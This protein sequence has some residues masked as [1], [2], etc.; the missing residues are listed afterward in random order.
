MIESGSYYE[1]GGR[2]WVLAE[3]FQR[4][5]ADVKFWNETAI[6]Y[7]RQLNETIRRGPESA[8]LHIIT[9]EQIN[10]AWAKASELL[11]EYYE[12]VPYEVL[13][14]FGIVACEKC[15]GRGEL[16]DAV[17]AWDIPGAPIPECQ[18]C[19]G[20]GWVMEVSDE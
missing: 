2:R 11:G 7:K 8:G 16:P 6:E 12:D 17:Q 14:C 9:T 1:F 4:L 3:D 20:N 10:R 19:N 13:E 18:A 5:R 15:G